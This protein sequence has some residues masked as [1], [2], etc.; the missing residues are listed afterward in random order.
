MF[1]SLFA[2]ITLTVIIAVAPFL[3]GAEN[4]PKMKKIVMLGMRTDH[5]KGEH[6]Y[7]AGLA[8]LAECLKQ[9][10]GV[11]VTVFKVNPNPK[12]EK[13]KEWEPGWPA[14]AKALE[15]ANTIV[16]FCKT[17]GTYFLADGER[18]EKLETVLKKGAGFVALHWAVETPKALGTPEYLSI[19]GGY[20]EPGYSTNPHNKATV[21]QPDSKHPVA[22]G[23]KPF[24]AT[25]EFYF[26]MRLMPEAKPVLTATLKGYDKKEYKDETIGWVYERKGQKGELGDGRSFGFTGCHFHK[27][28]DIAEFRRMIVN[29]ILWTS[30]VEVPQDGA[31]VMLKAPVPAIPD[32]K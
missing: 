24:E 29:G 31:P 28:W 21:Q 30:G 32:K 13:G 20:Y 17:A 19:L 22:R 15:D 23:W 11:D 4:Q 26:K 25:D 8:V 10:P 16:C 7:M 18:K 27:N 12:K 6:E 5:A 1:K 9:T 14:E 2:L 3:A